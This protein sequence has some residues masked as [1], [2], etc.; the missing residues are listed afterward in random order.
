MRKHPRDAESK[1][2]FPCQSRAGFLVLH[3]IAFDS[4]SEALIA[5]KSPAFQFYVTDYLG[6]QRVQMLTLEEEGAYIRLLC[7]C[8]QH[9]SIPSNP[10]EM[11]RLIGKG[12]STTLATTLQPMF[13]KHPNQKGRLV[14]ERLE[15]ERAKQTAWREKSIAGG[16]KSGELRRKQSNHPSTTLHTV[17]EKC[18]EPNGNSP[19]PSP[20]PNKVHKALKPRPSLEEVKLTIAKCGLPES[21]A[22]WFWNKC[23]GNG[24]MNGG[25]PIKS[26]PHTIASWKA[27]GYMPSQKLINNGQFNSKPQQKSILEKEIERL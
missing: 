16:K 5:V 15:E 22:V 24:W 23:E 27:A 11:A 20:S 17:V 12:A 10:K 14:H 4:G 25:K 13:V 8:W 3:H 6:S 1:S 7:F 9:G 21:D 19:S 18:L 26:W 2:H